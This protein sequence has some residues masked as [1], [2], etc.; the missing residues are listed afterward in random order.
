LPDRDLIEGDG[1]MAAHG[2]P[3]YA[4]AAGNDYAAHESTY[5]RFVFLVFIAICHIVSICI[6]L[7]V[8]GVKGAWWTAFAIFVLA[9]IAAIHGLMSGSKASSG[10]VVVLALLALALA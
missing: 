3:E 5:E 9:T 2:N 4:I 7:A 8:G 6:G 1:A 10:I